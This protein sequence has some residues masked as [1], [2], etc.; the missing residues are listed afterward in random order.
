MTVEE[1][2]TKLSG[3]WYR[4]VNLDHHKDRDCH[5]YIEKVWSYGDP[6]KYRAVHQGYIAEPYL[7]KYYPSL[8][9]AE[10]GVLRYLKYQ[11]AGAVKW[12]TDPLDSDDPYDVQEMEHAKALMREMGWIE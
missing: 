2:I 10:I 3:E 4:Y 8:E 12:A 5:F 7:N 11:I 6:P 9:E 1:E